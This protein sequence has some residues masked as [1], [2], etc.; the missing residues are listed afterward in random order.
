MKKNAF[1]LLLSLFIVLA[2]SLLTYAESQKELQGKIHL[3]NHK[4]IAMNSK[5]YIP[6]EKIADILNSSHNWSLSSNE[7][8]GYLDGDYFTTSDFV[9][10]YGDL[11]LPL[12]FFERKFNIMIKISG[13]NYF[14]YV[15]KN[16]FP[17]RT[18]DLE[19]ELNTDKK[20]YEK[21]DPIAISILLLNKSNEKK[22]LKFNSSKKYNITVKRNNRVIWNSSKDKAFLQ[23]I[24]YKEIEENGHL[25]YT[26]V[27]N[28]GKFNTENPL[29]LPSAN[30]SIIV[31][32]ETMNKGVIRE[33]L[34]IKIK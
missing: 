24:S 29:F 32:I 12:E 15:I 3:D 2:F 14:V 17:E 22:I 23:V 34:N 18:D 13:N 16:Y 31:E 27:L 21:N 5:E 7:I 19:L 30:Y 8:H 11:Y 9:I 6:L 20:I 25:L 28:P 26:T 4:K 1:V 33:E 10:A